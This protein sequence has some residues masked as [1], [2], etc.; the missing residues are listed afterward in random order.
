[1]GS[2]R[3][4]HAY[5][6][7]ISYAASFTIYHETKEETMTTPLFP[8]LDRNGFLLVLLRLILLSKRNGEPEY[9]V[10]PFVFR[11]NRFTKVEQNFV[12]DR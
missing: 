8:L 3:N 1:M 10:F 4:I 11:F 6:S 7:I 2:L 12:Y 9:G 5:S